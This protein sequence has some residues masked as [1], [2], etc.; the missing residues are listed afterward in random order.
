VKTDAAEN[1]TRRRFV[2]GTV[3]HT[4]TKTTAFA[5]PAAGKPLAPFTIDR[6]E[7]GA[8]DVE[9]DVLFCGVCHSD[10]H[11]ARDEWTG[12]TFPMVPG[13][14]VVGRVSRVGAAVKRFAKGALVGVGCMVDSCR[15]CGPCRHDT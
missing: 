5:A 6:R 10:I 7:P 14:E 12:A 3:V 11:Q 8:S 9:I 13:H 4:M 2:E 1:I 15:T